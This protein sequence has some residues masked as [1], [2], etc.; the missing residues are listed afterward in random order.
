MLAVTKNAATKLAT[1]DVTVPVPHATEE[2]LADL[3]AAASAPIP[4]D[5]LGEPNIADGAL[6]S[7]LVAKNAGRQVKNVT[8]TPKAI[9]APK[10]AK[11]KAKPVERVTAEAFLA[12]L[13]RLGLSKSQAASALG[14]SPSSVSEYSG[15]G[16]KRLMAKDR[17]TDAKAKLALFAKGLK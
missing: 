15:A 2:D 8:P 7:D 4:T 6:L 9:A 17:W 1:E 10:A 12:E 3:A 13:K 11:P 5:P 16:R 14:V